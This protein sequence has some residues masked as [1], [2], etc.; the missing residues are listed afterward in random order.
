VHAR[1]TQSSRRHSL[2]SRRRCGFASLACTRPRTESPW[3]A[4]APALARFEGRVA[5]VPESRMRRA[6]P[7]HPRPSRAT[8]PAQGCV[9]FGCCFGRARRGMRI[10]VWGLGLGVASG[11]MIC[12]CE[13]FGI[14]DSRYDESRGCCAGGSWM[15]RACPSHPRLGDS[16][17]NNVEARLNRRTR[18]SRAFRA[19]AGVHEDRESATAARPKG[20]TT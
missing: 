7:P 17:E 2:R 8:T 3:N 9:G 10:V 1:D 4:P 18:T 16:G 5:G 12:E 13:Y 14:S 15:R 19:R 20:V 11:T 6:R